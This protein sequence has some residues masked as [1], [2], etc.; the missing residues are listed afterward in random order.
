VFRHL[1]NDQARTVAISGEIE[2]ENKKIV[3]FKYR[4]I[5][6]VG[7]VI[8]SAF[9]LYDTSQLLEEKKEAPSEDISKKVQQMI[10]ERLA[11]HDLVY[12]VVDKKLAERDAIK[13]LMMAKITESMRPAD[14]VVVHVEEPV[15]IVAKSDAKAKKESPL[16][17]FLENRKNKQKAPEFNIEMAKNEHVDCP[18]CGKKIFDGAAFSGCICFGDD[19]DRKVHITKTEEGVKIR[20]GRGWDAENIEMLLEV[21]RSRRG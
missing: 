20:F 12:K 2:H 15:A 7:L 5:P 3:D 14:P 21:L 11:L 4:S 9:E 18:D 6:G 17:G 13:E 16:K 1:A 19:R 8:M 10:D